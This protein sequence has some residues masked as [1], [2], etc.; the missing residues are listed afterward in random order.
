MSVGFDAPAVR[1]ERL[2]PVKTI[3]APSF[4]PA[5][6][7]GDLK[8]L[9][10]YF[11]LLLTLTHHRIRV[12]Y[13]QSVLGIVWAVLQPLALMAIYTVIFSVVTRVPTGGTP[14]AIF[15]F[16]A[17]LPWTFFASTITT[18][19][20]CLVTHNQLIT[21]V[22]FPREILPLTYLFA[23]AF[24]LLIASLV[25]AGMMIYYHIAPGPQALWVIPILLVAALFA[26][27]MALMLSAAQVWFRD[28]GLAIPLVLQLWMFACPVVYPLASVPSRFR[29]VYDLD[30]MAGVIENFRRVLLEGKAPDGDSLWMA[31]AI[32]LALVA[33]AYLF[34]KNRE[35][36]MADVI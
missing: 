19:V 32:T 14:Y 34:F 3:S 1:S 11:D 5:R 23:A 35:A 30:P 24:D 8:R 15:V 36:T 29:V 16:T 21:K 9:T 6:F 22:Y 26:G 28:I 33:P 10:E 27:S 13:K 12:R 4:S 31:A 7:A 20:N 17:L 25:L 18:G 2:R